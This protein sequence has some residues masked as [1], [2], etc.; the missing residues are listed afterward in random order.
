MGAFWNMSESLQMGV[1]KQVQSVFEGIIE[2]PG[3]M[4]LILEG[5]SAQGCVQFGLLLRLAC[6]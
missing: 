6:T 2:I 5:E 4:N 1:L 3:F